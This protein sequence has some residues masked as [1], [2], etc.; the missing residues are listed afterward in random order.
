MFE[1]QSPSKHPP[2][3]AI[4]QSRCFFHRS[5]GLSSSVLM[6][7]SA[8]AVFCFASSISAKC[9]PLRTFSSGKQKKV[10]EGEIG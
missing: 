9:F 5:R 1:L 7:V 4:H 8:S 3:D 6:A 10:A 2:F